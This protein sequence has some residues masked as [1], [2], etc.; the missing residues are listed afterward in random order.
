MIDDSLR[1]IVEEWLES[2]L[3]TSL[4]QG[5][6]ERVRVV[7]LASPEFALRAIRFGEKHLI[8]ARD[9]WVPELESVC[10]SLDPDLL[11]SVFG[12]YE[13]ARV[14]MPRGCAV[15]G[16][17]WWLFADESSWRPRVTDAAIQLAGNQHAQVDFDLFW[18]CYPPE[19]SVAA[20]GIYRDDL[21]ALATVKDLGRPFMEI[22]VDVA[23]GSQERGLGSSVV[24][25]AGNWILS[26]GR[27]PV[28]SVGPFNVPSA[29]TL[30][31]VGLAYG[32]S[33]L[34]S[35]PGPFRV[36]PQP[37]GKPLPN[38]DLANHYPDWAMNR[39]IRPR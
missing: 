23:P 21:A 28:A 5:S 33:D 18:H 39:D 26:Q 35:R 1:S 4:S 3:T 8:V 20:F 6:A 15:W 34:I 10:A 2:H 32:F 14:A 13:L 38:A 29:R 17:T 11:F 31:G 37:L 25:A 19:E 16:P 24:S 9:S 7:A 27:L 30:R 36:P 22:D 12:T